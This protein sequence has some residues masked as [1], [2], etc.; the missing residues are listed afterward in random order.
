MPPDDVSMFLERGD[1]GL[2]TRAKRNDDPGRRRSMARSKDQSRD[3][4]SKDGQAVLPLPYMTVSPTELSYP[5]GHLD[6]H[7]GDGHVTM[8]DGG[9]ELTDHASIP[10]GST[11]DKM[12]P[13]DHSGRFDDEG[14]SIYSKAD[15]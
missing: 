5:N 12:P 14:L 8:P 13:R 11:S 9:L 10:T 3:K 2:S 1:H 6:N 15:T 7:E 4:K